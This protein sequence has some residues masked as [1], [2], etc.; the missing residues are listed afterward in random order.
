VSRLAFA[1]LAGKRVDLF[2]VDTTH[3]TMQLGYHLAFYEF[4]VEYND[5]A[6]LHRGQRHHPAAVTIHPVPLSDLDLTGHANVQMA[7][8]R[9][10]PNMAR[11]V[12]D[13]STRGAYFSWLQKTNEKG[14]SFAGY[15][16][17]DPKTDLAWLTFGIRKGYWNDV[18]KFVFDY[19]PHGVPS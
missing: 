1:K 4:R 9:T 17:R 11:V 12:V 19:T 15:R 7:S 5:G 18:G 14:A 3:L 16:L 13:D 10:R 8:R 2:A 6:P